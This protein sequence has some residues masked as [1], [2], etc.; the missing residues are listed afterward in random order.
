MDSIELPLVIDMVVGHFVDKDSDDAQ[1]E[2]HI[3]CD[4]N[5]QVAYIPTDLLSGHKVIAQQ[6]V[7][8]VNYH[9]M[10]VRLLNDLVDEL[11]GPDREASQIVTELSLIRQARE[12]LEEI[13]K[14][15]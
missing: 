11:C 15:K 4:Q 8:A 6:F 7:K 13:E 14:V 10:L 2:A 1:F 12:L 5:E 9:D 3:I